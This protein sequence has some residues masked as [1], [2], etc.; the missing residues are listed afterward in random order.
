MFEYIKHRRRGPGWNV[1]YMT[2][3]PQFRLGRRGSLSKYH[4]GG[5]AQVPGPG[6]W[7]LGLVP[8]SV[9][10]LVCFRAA[11]RSSR[12]RPIHA[13]DEVELLRNLYAA[14]VCVYIASAKRSW[15][16]RDL[17]KKKTST[18]P[19]AARRSAPGCSSSSFPDMTVP[20]GRIPIR[21]P[22][23]RTDGVT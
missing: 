15:R 19:G 18:S 2:R 22:A 10:W 1:P 17:Q 14:N 4:I 8:R 3:N 12:S 21:G 20:G 5:P 11:A 6:A 7:A 9:V 13:E 23:F 16:E